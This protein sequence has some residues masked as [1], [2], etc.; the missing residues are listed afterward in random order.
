MKRWSLPGGPCLP[1]TRRVRGLSR[2]PVVS[3]RM[4]VASDRV[5]SPN[6]GEER[7][8]SRATHTRGTVRRGLV[9]PRGDPLTLAAPS[10]PGKPGGGADPSASRCSTRYGVT[11][12]PAPTCFRPVAPLSRGDPG[13]HMSRCLRPRSLPGFP[14]WSCE[15]VPSRAFVRWSGPALRLPRSFVLSG[16]CN[17]E[18]APLIPVIPQGFACVACRCEPDIAGR[19]GRGWEGAGRGGLCGAMR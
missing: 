5:T 8:I 6:P 15:P 2:L 16:W 17:G 10:R 4:A 1:R 12:R 14:R 13:I 9:V 7:P 19:P 18:N 3:G 11:P